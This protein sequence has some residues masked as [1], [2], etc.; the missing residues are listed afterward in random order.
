MQEQY[1]WQMQNVYEFQYKLQ[2]HLQ[3]MNIT[4][5]QGILMGSWI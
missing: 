5:K 4:A 1:G 2:W 3:K